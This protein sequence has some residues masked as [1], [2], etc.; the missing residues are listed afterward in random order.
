MSGGKIRLC[1]DLLAVTVAS[2]KMC[3]VLTSC[4]SASVFACSLIHF[5]LARSPAVSA[6]KTQCRFTSQNETSRRRVPVKLP[7]V[8]FGV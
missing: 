6:A 1:L 8:G 2:I 7:V 5:T 3:H 4:P